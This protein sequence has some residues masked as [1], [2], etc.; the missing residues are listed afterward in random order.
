MVQSYEKLP[1]YYRLKQD[2][3]EKINNEE[4]K[5]DEKIPSERLFIESYSVSRITVRKAVDE[6]CNEGYLYRIQGKGTYVKGGGVKQDLFSITSCTEDIRKQGMTPKRKVN[7]AE[8]RT[9]DVK[10]RNLLQLNDED[11]LFL[12]DRV[13][14]ADDLPVNRTIAYLSA[15]LFADI[16]THDFS[17][18]SLYEV[19]ENK[20]GV[21]ITKATRTIEAVNATGETAE[22][23]EVEEGKP[24]ILFRAIT[25]GL[26]DG[27]D[28]EIPIET[29][30]SFYRT[31]QFKFYI[32]QIKSD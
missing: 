32:N 10:R 27:S 12:L 1:K 23:L 16:E 3:I 8:I 9:P 11:R 14:Y 25:Y 18:Q 15:G 4:W 24:I 19:L 22:L 26:I 17:T 2:I 30:K 7:A 6:L 31:D 29:F 28:Q 20:Y 21:T 13:Y 5:F